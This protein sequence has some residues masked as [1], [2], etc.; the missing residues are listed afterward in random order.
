MQG[1]MFNE[2]FGLFTAVREGR[3]TRTFRIG[4]KQRYKQGQVVFVKEPFCFP[5]EWDAHPASEI[6]QGTPCHYP[7]TD[8]DKPHGFGRIR[9]KMFMPYKHS[10]FCILFHR[11]EQRLLRDLTNEDAECEG[12]EVMFV[13]DET[14]DACAWKNYIPTVLRCFFNQRQSFFSL[15]DAIC[16]EGTAQQN[17]R[18]TAYYFELYDPETDI[19]FY[20]W[21]F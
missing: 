12:I 11:V 9:G 19:N 18:G 1:I 7:Y 16:G 17:P 4:K 14:G 8:G 20:W 3:K 21:I 6:P 2:Q 10:R 13:E 5:V 15:I